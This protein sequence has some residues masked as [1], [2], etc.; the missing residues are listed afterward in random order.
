[1]DKQ[2]RQSENQEKL[3]QVNRSQNIRLI[4]H[5]FQLF[6]IVE[7]LV[8]I[9][10]IFMLSYYQLYTP[11]RNEE[12]RLWVSFYYSCQGGNCFQNKNLC[13]GIS[14]SEKYK[15]YYCSN[16][17]DFNVFRY[18][19]SFILILIV[20]TMIFDVYR[21]M[22]IKNELKNEILSSKLIYKAKKY[23]IIIILLLFSYY[24]ILF[25]FIFGIDGEYGSAALGSAFFVGISGF[26][27]Y[28]VI[29][30]YFRYLKGRL[31]RESYFEKLL[32]E[33]LDESDFKQN[34][35]FKTVE[36]REERF[37]SVPEQDN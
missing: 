30:L 34:F 32:N 16:T 14:P 5:T 10:Q 7:T 6:I 17:Q 28:M 26:F 13:S 23:Q 2:F 3:I 33:G 12:Y 31:A 18:I 9:S 35:E 24:V 15:D 22:K 29:I 37:Y 27:T 36:C 8:I 1:M 21:M 19:L 4:K 11:Y 20:L 25:I